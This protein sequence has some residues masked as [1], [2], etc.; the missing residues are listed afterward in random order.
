MT[1]ATKNVLLVG[2]ERNT[3]ERVVPLLNRREIDVLSAPPSRAVLN[4]LRDT[5]FDLLIVRYPLDQPGLEE[6]LRQVRAP[7]SFCH[8][9]GVILVSDEARMEEAMR[10]E[11]AGV[12]RVMANRWTGAH[13]WQ[14]LAD[15]LHVA[16]RVGVRVLAHLDIEL[17]REREEDVARS[18]NI[19][20]SGVLLESPASIR[21]GTRVRM[22]FR[23]PQELRPVSGGGEVVRRSDP[24]REGVQGFAVRFLNLENDGARRVESWIARRVPAL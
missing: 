12:N 24:D 14:T 10:F 20:A 6:L 17:G 2:V 4:L 18:V 22:T 5:P 16:P 13:L 19:S 15:L 3:V 23:L 9:A 11:G 7:E 8:N 21:P 1:A